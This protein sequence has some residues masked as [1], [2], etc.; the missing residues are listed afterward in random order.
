[1]K[2]TPQNSLPLY[3]GKRL[4]TNPA[5]TVVIYERPDSRYLQVRVTG[6]TIGCVRRSARTR[7]HSTAA[8]FGELLVRHLQRTKRQP[9]PS[10]LSSS[11]S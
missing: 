8:Q 1:M 4:K 5:V 7:E 10:A 6:Q 3:R 9:P 11:A 2:P